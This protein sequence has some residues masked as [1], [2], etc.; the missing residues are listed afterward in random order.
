MIQHSPEGEVTDVGYRQEKESK[1]L[2]CWSCDPKGPVVVIIGLMVPIDLR[3]VHFCP[4]HGCQIHYA[5]VNQILRS[6]AEVVHSPIHS[7]GM[8][9]RAESP[10]SLK[11]SNALR[12]ELA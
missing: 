11:L 3:S 6:V 8:K 5:T 7:A 1:N 4:E 12:C 2:S 10:H 9:L